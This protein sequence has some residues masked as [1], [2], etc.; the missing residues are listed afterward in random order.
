M[1][2]E[3][4]ASSIPLLAWA[5]PVRNGIFLLRDSTHTWAAVHWLSHTTALVGYRDQ[6][7]IARWE[8]LNIQTGQ[9]RPEST[10]G[11]ALAPHRYERRDGSF[12]VVAASPDGKKLLGFRDQNQ[13]RNSVYS[14]VW[15]GGREQ[16][17]S[18]ENYADFAD[19][20]WL[21]D[22]KGWF[23]PW[24]SGED[25]ATTL[26][27]FELGKRYPQPCRLRGLPQMTPETVWTRQIL[28]TMPSGEAILAYGQLTNTSDVKSIVAPIYTVP[29]EDRAHAR[30]LGTLRVPVPSI[31]SIRGPHEANYYDSVQVSPA[32]DCLLWQCEHACEE[33]GYTTSLHVCGLDGSNFREIGHIPVHRPT[34]GGTIWDGIVLGGLRWH[35]DSRHVSFFYGHVSRYQLYIAAVPS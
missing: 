24:K 31:P 9:R 12:S 19:L 22:S 16:T 20:M 25:N 7:N 21:P 26:W 18:V 35:P 10:F 8:H 6:N 4:T 2:H 5:T 13:N 33:R 32:G 30:R 27:C 11:P 14:V 1:K 29:I 3:R 15:P 28:G 34:P 23:S 17:W